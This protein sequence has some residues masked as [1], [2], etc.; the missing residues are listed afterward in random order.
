MD[1]FLSKTDFGKL[2]QLLDK[3]AKLDMRLT[4]L[5]ILEKGQQIINQS[6]TFAI[7]CSLAWKQESKQK[8]ERIVSN[9]EIVLIQNIQLKVH[10]CKVA[11]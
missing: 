6:N 5:K 4:K 9:Q 10:Y 3:R 2:W 7:D 1:I 8:R 11:W